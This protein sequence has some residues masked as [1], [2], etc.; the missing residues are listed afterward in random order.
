MDVVVTITKSFNPVRIVIFHASGIQFLVE[1]S[2]PEEA[3]K[4]KDALDGREI[5][6]GCCLL[7][8][9]YSK[10]SQCLNVKNNNERSWDFTKGD[11]I[12]HN[13]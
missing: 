10:E 6:A 12:L 13:E 8:V 11:Y 9:V 1:F 5:Y 2:T 4:A 3:K 7:K